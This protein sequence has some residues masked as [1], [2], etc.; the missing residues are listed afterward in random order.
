MA[1]E[2]LVS[3]S[4]VELACAL[5]RES[6]MSFARES[7]SMVAPASSLSS[8]RDVACASPLAFMI[9]ERSPRCSAFAAADDCARDLARDPSRSP[10]VWPLANALLNELANEFWFGSRLPWMTP[11]LAVESAE[12]SASSCSA[13]VPSPLTSPQMRKYT[14]NIFIV[15]RW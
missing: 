11:V 12:A 14:R 6:A 10:F 7:M 3:D 2:L 1:P 13:L 4:A 5:A 15:D 9:L 8:P